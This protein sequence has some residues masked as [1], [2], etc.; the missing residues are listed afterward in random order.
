[1]KKLGLL[2]IVALLVG[3]LGGCAYAK[4]K[5]TQDTYSVEVT[6]FGQD[7]TGSDLEATLDPNAKTTIRAGTVDNLASP[8]TSDSLAATVEL[9]RLIWEI[10]T[11]TAPVPAP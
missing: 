10:K 4:M 5:K 1:M 3:L 9:I 11:A 2:V 7:F 6:T 8:V